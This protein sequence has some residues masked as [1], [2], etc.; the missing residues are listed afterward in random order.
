[1]TNTTLVVVGV[2]VL[3]LLAG[4]TSTPPPPSTQV[5]GTEMVDSIGEGE[6]MMIF[7]YLNESHTY[8]ESRISAVRWK[9]ANGDSYY[10]SSLDPGKTNLEIA[11]ERKFDSGTH[12]LVL[13]RD[14]SVIV[15][16]EIEITLKTGI[17][18]RDIKTMRITGVTKV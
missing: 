2:V 6:D 11:S 3:A 12:T 16:L 13:I 4:C 15:E 5:D 7:V 9:L 18:S 17:I 10:Y 14:E 1:M 8:G